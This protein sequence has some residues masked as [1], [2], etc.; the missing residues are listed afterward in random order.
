ME[1]KLPRRKNLRLKNYDYSQPGYYFVTI[2]TENRRNLLCN[3]VGND[4][5]VV[6]SEIGNEIIQC[7]ENIS[8]LYE[9]VKTDGFCIMPNHIHGI[10][11]IEDTKPQ[12]LSE[13]TYG[14]QSAERRGRRSLPDIIKDFKSVTARQYNKL[15]EIEFRNT[16]WQKSYYEHII[17]NEL[18]LQEIREYIVNNPV[19]WVEDEYYI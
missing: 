7:W 5:P 17:R 11:V 12:P 4:A 2:C 16:L 8:L 10:I 13:K 3:I 9:N 19:K 1:N 15:V 14:F 18:E 6:P